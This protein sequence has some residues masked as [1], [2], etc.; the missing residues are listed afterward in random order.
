MRKKPRF[1]LA[2]VSAILMLGL[3][4]CSRTINDI[5]KWKASGNIE[6]LIGALEDPK[7]EIRK[8]AATALGELKA[9]PAV[10]PI[11]TLLNDPDSSVGLSAVNALVSIGNEPAT[12]QLITALQLEN[13]EARTSAAS[14]LGTLKAANA[15]DALIGTLDDSE[16]T[17]ACAGAAALGL[18]GD[19]KASGPLAAK[20]KAPST[21]L[22]L[23][24]VQALANTKGKAAI[25]GLIGALA[26]DNADVRS[27]AI[28]ALS[29]IGQASIPFV[30]DALKDENKAI[31]R[32]A[33]AVL[34][35]TDSVPAAGNNLIWYQL[36]RVSVDSR[37]SLDM[38]VVDQLARMGND[39]AETL[40]EAAG[41]SATDVH[42][43]AFRALETIGE[44][45]AEKAGEAAAEY[46]VSDASIW[47]NTRATWSGAP[48]WRIDLWS[49]VAALNPGFSLDSA[50][51]AKMKMQGRSAFRVISPPDFAPT[52]EYIPLL[53]DLL[54]DT[55]KPPPK[56]PD[57]DKFG[58][59]V[60]KKAVDR[61][62]G[63]ANQQMAKDKLI[64]AGSIAV[65]P[66]IAAIDDDNAL[67]SANVAEVLGEIGD[68]RA[69]KPLITALEQ[70]LKKGDPLS[71]SRFYSALQKL[72][73]PAAEP[74]L[75]KI[76]PNTD[77]AIRIFERQYPDVRVNL[78]E[79]R[80]F[81]G[82]QTLPI[83]FRVGYVDNSEK[84]GKTDLTFQKDSS[85]NWIPTPPLQDELP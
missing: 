85:G 12:V 69:V 43:H 65:F 18:I 23:T 40:L 61:F 2:A 13:T 31:R 80:D 52:R 16:H 58:M 72:D 54:G 42:E 66:L 36:A 24:C 45:C 22:R 6:K 48:S 82:Q 63:E 39:A 3:F 26:D 21:K 19:E 32:G 27:G 71:N 84:V 79:S 5:A 70:K 47:F 56:Q 44:S 75:L 83:T 49:A 78:A 28:D 38:A 33:L 25:K 29:A 77:R 67:I 74:I 81:T 57:V 1:I 53:I 8:G 41:H 50:A 60:I 7:P 10:D 51:A 9:E 34:K 30:L 55:T 46:A 15:V 76:R 11:A 35:K 64:Q 59:P 73:D 14:G 20:L 17:V 68:P 37:K 4:G 62:R